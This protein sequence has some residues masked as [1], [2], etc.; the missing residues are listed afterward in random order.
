V[1]AAVTAAATLTAGS[2]RRGRPKSRPA[3]QICLR[4][5]RK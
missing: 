3:W 5:R 2:Q 1:T 4:L